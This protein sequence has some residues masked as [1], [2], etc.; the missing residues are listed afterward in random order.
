MK[1]E[2]SEGSGQ[3]KRYQH[4]YIDFFNIIQ[5]AWD[6]E[7]ILEDNEAVKISAELLKTT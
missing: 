5:L 7:W 4:I 6:I 3:Y 1:R 2:R